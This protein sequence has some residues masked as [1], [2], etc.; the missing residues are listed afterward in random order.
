MCQAIELSKQEFE[1]QKQI[2]Q[3]KKSVSIDRLFALCG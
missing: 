2:K 3:D 1:K